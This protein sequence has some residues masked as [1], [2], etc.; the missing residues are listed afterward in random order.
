M[1]DA[2]LVCSLK[3]N[4]PNFKLDTEFSVRKGELVCIIGPSG[5]GKSTTLSILSGLLDG[6][7]GTSIILDGNDITHLAPEK[8]QVALVFQDY[9]IFPQMNVQ[10]NIAYPL[11]LQKVP[12]KE[13]T[14]KISAWLDLVSLS[15]FQKRKPSQLS[16]GERQRVA[17]ARALASQPKLLLLDEPLS[18]L[19]T[20]L[21]RHLR[22][23]I[24]RIHDETG[25]TMVY[26]THDQEEAMAIADRIIVMNQGHIEQMGDPEELYHH[27]QTL[28]TATFMGDGTTM[29]YSII[30]ETLKS[31]GNS[32]VRFAPKQGEQVIF[33]RPE[34]VTV[35][36][37]SDLPFPEYLPH[38]EFQD[39]KLVSCIFQGAVF[40]AVF[41]WHT[42]RIGAI[43]KKRPKQDY[44]TL[45]VRLV[46]IRQFLD[47]EAIR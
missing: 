4:Y 14:A 23:E 2:G 17:L 15:G 38:L 47:G 9:A 31:E 3:A 22:E 27:P 19:D 8:R 32:Y 40:E 42:Y 25:V 36:D 45:G 7:T 11:K 24:R 10:D 1:Q 29:P 6:D 5:C 26:V 35:Q 41:Q 46:D 20:K 18:A 28:F 43:V 30:A 34:Q 33:F 12:R 13:R 16:G 21:R 39:A 44:A 37:D